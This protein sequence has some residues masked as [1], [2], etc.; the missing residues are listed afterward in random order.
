MKMVSTG[1]EYLVEDVGYFTPKKVKSDHLSSGEIGF[2]N[3]AIKELSDCN[4]GDTLTYT[5]TEVEL[6]LVLKR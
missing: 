1:S 2:I 5:D 4:I 3:A 6:C